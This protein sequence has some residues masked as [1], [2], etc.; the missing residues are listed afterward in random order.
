MLQ[1]DLSDQQFNCLLKCVLYYRLDSI[2]WKQGLVWC[3]EGNCIPMEWLGQSSNTVVFKRKLISLAMISDIMVRKQ[4]I[5]HDR[6]ICHV[7]S[8]AP[9]R[10]ASNLK[11]TI[12]IVQIEVTRKLLSCEC[13]MPAWC[14][15]SIG[16]C[17]GLVPPDIKPLLQL[18]LTQIYVELS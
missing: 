17:N 10:S 8:L 12:F 2:T 15:I 18:L 4:N 5:W 6:S 9:V 14:W 13:Y 1:L 11:N 3:P 16:S 7:N